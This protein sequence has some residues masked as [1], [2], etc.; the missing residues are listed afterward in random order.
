MELGGRVRPH[1]SF[2]MILSG[3][4]AVVSSTAD[5]AVVLLDEGVKGVTPLR[6]AETEAR[7]GET[8]LAVGYP[9]DLDHGGIHRK[10]RFGKGEVIG[11]SVPNEG[12]FLMR[13]PSQRTDAGMN[14]GPCLRE[15]ASG[16]VLAGIL[17][18]GTGDHY[19]LTS[20]QPY[21]EWLLEQI[22]QAEGGGD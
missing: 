20:I 18:G 1:P 22:R 14:G 16:T 10:R 6:L 3:D 8:L 17:R 21:R 4:G 11:N 13:H 9:S 15:T 12:V 19:L 7:A 2:K 5:L